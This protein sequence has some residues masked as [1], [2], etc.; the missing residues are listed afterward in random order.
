MK[1]EYSP[2]VA[3]QVKDH[4]KAV[5]FYKRVLGMEFIE[6]S[7]NDVYL[8]KDV[9]TFVFE[10]KPDGAHKNTFFEFRVDDV[11]EAK[12]LLESE[13][14]KVLQIYNEKS[15][16]F[17]DPYGMNFHIWEDGAFADKP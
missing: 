14:C 6:A 11:N 9:I 17:S 12:T 13:G 8:K 1:F 3:L 10:N 7:D 2:Y 4:D 5:D 16:M 15:I